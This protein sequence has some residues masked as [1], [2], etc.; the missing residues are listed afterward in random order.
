MR[1]SSSCRLKG[2]RDVAF[3]RTR[4][5]R[6]GK[7]R[8]FVQEDALSKFVR[9]ATGLCTEALAAFK[10]NLPVLGSIAWWGSHYLLLWNASIASLGLVFERIRRQVRAHG[11]GHRG[12]SW[13]HGPGRV[14]QAALQLF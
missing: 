2:R 4:E 13:R 14:A 11:R 9:E 6:A 12:C 3:A 1:C 10:G 7:A 8:G 5:E